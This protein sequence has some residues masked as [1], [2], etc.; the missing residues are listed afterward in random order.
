LS[1][2]PPKINA[3]GQ[4]GINKRAVQIL[5][6]IALICFM[7]VLIYFFHDIDNLKRFLPWGYVGV[8]LVSLISN[9]TIIFPVPGDLVVWM[10]GAILPFFWVGVIASIGAALGELT[11]YFAG[12]WGRVAIKEKHLKRLER[13]ESW[14]KR[15][16]SPVVFLF[17]LTPLPFDI[18]GIAAGS[19]RFPL[20][21]F[22][23]ACWA[24]KLPR[25]IFI[26]YLG[27]ISVRLFFP[28]AF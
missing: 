1:P 22:F 12:Y 10:A 15:H 16:G 19:L 5:A 2:L 7:G 26:A 24:G 25:A 6:V 9:C 28:G 18:V 17:A 13:A 11:G 4:R 21:K 3:L 23:L 20:W 27:S 14:M 8:F